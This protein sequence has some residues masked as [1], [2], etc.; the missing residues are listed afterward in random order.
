LNECLIGGIYLVNH[1]STAFKNRILNTTDIT[2]LKKELGIIERIFS[3]NEKASEEMR[4]KID[5]MK[6]RIKV[7]EAE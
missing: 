3:E 5:Y 4:Q 6:K 2:V 7:L 1:L